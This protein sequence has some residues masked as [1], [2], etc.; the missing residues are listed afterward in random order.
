MS[1]EP[2]RPDPDA[3]LAEA[4]KAGRGRLKVF[5]GAAPGVGKTY[6]MLEEARARRTAGVEVVVA[7]V[8]THG[9]PETAALLEG[10]EQ[11]PRRELPYKGRL[12]AE[13]DLDAL[14]ARRPQLALIDEFAHTNVPGSRHAKRWQDIM[15]V[16]D[17]GIDVVTTVNIQHVESLNDVVASITGV[18]VQ[19]TVPDDVLARADDIELI[20]LTPEAL[21]ERLKEGKVYVPDQAGLALDNFF[22]KGNLTALREL[23]LRTAA[24]RV[25][26]DV[27]AWMRSHGVRGPWPTQ[28]R[29]LVCLSDAP[30]AKTLVRAARRMADRARIPWIAVTVLTPRHESLGGEAREN[31]RAAL[32]LAETLGGEA[33]QLHAESDVAAELLAYARKRNVT[34]LVIGRPRTAGWGVVARWFREPVFRRL[35]DGAGDFE[36]TVVTPKS[37]ARRRKPAVAA[38]LARRWRAWGQAAF[39]TAAVITIATAVAWP[40]WRLVPLGSLAVVYLFGV[41]LI[42]MRHGL[43]GALIG[44]V[45]GFLAYNFFF[46]RPYFT[47]AVE[48]EEAIAALLVFLVSAVFTGTLASRLK[49]QVESMRASQ[50]RTETLY[51]F[52]RKIASA[53][54]A[55]DVLWAAAAHIAT[56]LNCRS[57]ILMPDPDGRLEQV[58]GHPSIEESLDPRDE[59][60]AQWAFTRNEPAGAGT[61]TLPTAPWLFVPLAT[62]KN[63]IGV[64]G[65]WFRDRSQTLDPE[66]RRLLTAVEDQVAVAVERLKLTADLEASRLEAES[67]KLRAALLNSVSHDLRT[68]LVSVIGALTGLADDDGSLD[69]EDRRELLATALDEARR[70]DRFV[71]NLLDMTRLG[72]GALTLRRAPVA[73]RE[74]VGRARADLARPLAGHPVEVDVPRDIHVDVDPVLIGQAVINVL[75]NAAKYAPPGTPVRIAATTNGAIVTLT[76][77]D[78]GPGIPPEDSERVF[79]LFYRVR[80]GDGQPAGTGLGLAI[81]RGLVEAHGGEVKARPGEDGRGT[82]IELILP[83]ALPETDTGDFP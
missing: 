49:M 56:T 18:R 14:L 16:L 29:L 15:E 45:A 65:V 13:L 37:E 2:D 39:E 63:V 46:T 83:A 70:L 53:T 78:R 34:R 33:V 55:D 61:D 28:D 20:D 22:S 27:L 66:T 4:R 60:A 76:I 5:L 11:L 9:R 54:K 10:L 6:A 43:A 26:A 62:A 74:I 80:Q 38:V 19:E 68:P 24:S 51:D 64:V 59:M 3:L 36:V 35:I 57:L 8:E 23:A 30:T 71:Q 12:I 32:R 41:L 47:F 40:L 73:L 67:E 21:A 17:A 81:V 72:Y 1:P 58:Q 69:P 7:L 79:D 52:A 75:E 25:D 31:L 44:A 82:A 48:Q 50:R 77:A 42:G